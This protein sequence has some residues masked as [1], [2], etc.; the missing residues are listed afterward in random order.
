[1]YVRRRH[2]AANALTADAVVVPE[3]LERALFMRSL[4]QNLGTELMRKVGWWDRSVTELI[5]DAIAEGKAQR[6][7]ETRKVQRTK[8]HYLQVAAGGP[9]NKRGYKIRG[10]KKAT[11]TRPYGRAIY[12]RKH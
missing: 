3:A 12:P 7:S 10:E 11:C 9:R 8:S 6:S 2:E 4:E 1:M 5:A